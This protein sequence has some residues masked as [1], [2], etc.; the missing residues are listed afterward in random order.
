MVCDSYLVELL[1]SIAVSVP[2]VL[3]AVGVAALAGLGQQ[4]SHGV[5]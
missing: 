3:L 2:N 4:C 5:T 1:S